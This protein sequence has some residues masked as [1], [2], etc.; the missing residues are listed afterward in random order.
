MPGL[1]E[2]ITE[3]ILFIAQKMQ[4]LAG[5]N[6]PVF[7]SSREPV[8]RECFRVVQLS[9]YLSSGC[10]FHHSM[11]QETAC[12]MPACNEVVGL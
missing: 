10:F 5:I 3:W 12:G 7:F 4:K 2:V 9:F 6:Q 1:E 8:L 11:L